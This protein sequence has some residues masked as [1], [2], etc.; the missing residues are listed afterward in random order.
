ME[1]ESSINSHVH[2]GEKK[3]YLLAGAFKAQDS[4]G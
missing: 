1:K 4:K 2:K 3:T